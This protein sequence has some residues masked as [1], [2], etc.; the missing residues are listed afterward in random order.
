MPFENVHRGARI[1][2]TKVRPVA[3]LIRGKPLAEAMMILQTSKKRAAVFLRQAL[4]AAQSNADQGE[5]D[6]RRLFVSDARADSGP[7]VNR[8]RPKDRGRAF[9]I[10][11]RTS[12][13]TVAVDVME[14]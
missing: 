10:R 6:V 8:W 4:L 14:N 3:D 11:K 7:T 13:I 9:P 12:H 5:A 2:P 1:S